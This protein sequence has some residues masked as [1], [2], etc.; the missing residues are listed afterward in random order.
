MFF[1]LYISD[2]LLPYPC[3]KI[4]DDEYERYLDF[5]LIIE[6]TSCFTTLAPLL[7]LYYVFEIRFGS[8]NRLCRLLYW[9]LLEDHIISIRHS[10]TC[11]AT[12]NMKL[13]IDHLWNNKQWLQI[14]SKVLLNHLSWIKTCHLHL[15]IQIKYVS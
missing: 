9:I 11:S 13:L 7:S 5:T 12:G 15:L 4:L 6:T 2:V 10:R 14:W 8:H 3:L 1:Q